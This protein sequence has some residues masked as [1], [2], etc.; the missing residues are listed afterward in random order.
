MAGSFNTNTYSKRN[1]YPR[2]G[3]EALSVVTCLWNYSDRVG[4][5]SCLE[6]AVEAA[7][8]RHHEQVELPARSWRSQQKGAGHWAPRWAP[9]WRAGLACWAGVLGWALR[10]GR[11]GGYGRRTYGFFSSLLHQFHAEVRRPS[12]Q[13]PAS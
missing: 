6:A 9:R 10:A 2:K 4:G 13:L 7:E 8:A 12:M 5:G 11:C 1:R 3:H